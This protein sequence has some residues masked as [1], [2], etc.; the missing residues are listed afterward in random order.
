M[1][2]EDLGDPRIT[3]VTRS[4]SIVRIKSAMPG[5]TGKSVAPMAKT[6]G[7]LSVRNW[8]VRRGRQLL[9]DCRSTPRRN[10][11]LSPW[12]PIRPLEDGGPGIEAIMLDYTVRPKT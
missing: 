10:W 2:D 12:P 7:H 8:L 1:C 11:V 4:D 6:F 3:L 5:N 9:H